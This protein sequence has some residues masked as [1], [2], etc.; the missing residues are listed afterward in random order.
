VSA[1]LLLVPMDP[2]TTKLL[3]VGGAGFA[4]LFAAAIM[5]PPR[6]Q[7]IVNM[8]EP[9]PAYTI[10]T[11]NLDC[12]NK[13]GIDLTGISVDGHEC[14]AQ[15]S[16]PMFTSRETLRAAFEKCDVRSHI[17]ADIDWSKHI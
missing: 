11:K 10:K 6:P 3:I 13:L 15:L 8:P 7:L 2:I 4:S 14:T 1:V 12:L 9:K 16:R 5:T 17:E